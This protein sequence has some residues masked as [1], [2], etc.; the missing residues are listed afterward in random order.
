MEAISFSSKVS[1]LVHLGKNE[2]LIQDI[3]ACLDDQYRDFWWAPLSC[4]C[5]FCRITIHPDCL[6]PANRTAADNH[7][8][9]AGKTT[10][11][12]QAGFCGGGAL[13]LPPPSVGYYSFILMLPMQDTLLFNSRLT[14][15]W[16][17]PDVLA[18]PH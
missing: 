1:R 2:R 11:R 8:I 16:L 5:L 12:D 18:V 4:V 15:F 17:A 7:R 13:R 10:V 6:D 3:K 9:G 14:V